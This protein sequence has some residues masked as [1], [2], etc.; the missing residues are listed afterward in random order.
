MQK[1]PPLAGKSTMIEWLKPVYADDVLT[2]AAEVTAL[3]PR[4]PRNGLAELTIHAYNQHGDLVL[5]NVTEAVVKRRPRAA[6][7]P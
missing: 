6:G 4:S 2:T 1:A 7:A 5:T 3:I